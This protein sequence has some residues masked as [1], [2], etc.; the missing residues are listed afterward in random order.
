MHICLKQLGEGKGVETEED[1][2]MMDWV[3]L[4]DERWKRINPAK[5]LPKGPTIP[6]KIHWIWLARVPGTPQSSED[7][8]H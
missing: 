1:S 2:S 5:K 7:K 8:I 6:H 4:L 3:Q